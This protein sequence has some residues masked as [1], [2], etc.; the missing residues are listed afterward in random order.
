MSINISPKQFR[1]RSL[2]EFIGQT[3][4]AFGINPRLITLE[5]TETAVFDHEDDAVE[6]LFVLKSLGVKIALDDFGVGH[7]SL[8]KLKSLPIDE[9]KVDRAFLANVPENQADREIIL[10]ISRMAKILNLRL[11]MEGVETKTQYDYL[12]QIGCQNMQGF[13]L[14]KPAPIDTV[15]PL[16]NTSAATQSD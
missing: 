4:N 7:S 1:E 14:S 12:E 5:I 10:A 9:L 6:A 16:L 15:M 8:F 3:L 11:V 2:P 13:L